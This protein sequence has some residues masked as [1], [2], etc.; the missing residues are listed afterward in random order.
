MSPELTVNPKTGD[1]ISVVGFNVL[2]VLFRM[3]SAECGRI[4][5]IK[6]GIVSRYSWMLSP[7]HGH[8]L[9]ILKK[10]D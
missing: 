4:A 5:A 1:I 6:Q 10:L 2:T 8:Y 3:Q 9:V 7:C